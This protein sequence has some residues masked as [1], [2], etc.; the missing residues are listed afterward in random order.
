MKLIN[1]IRNVEL[2]TLKKFTCLYGIG[3]YCW[4]FSSF[5]IQVV[6]FTTFLY[7]NGG[8]NIL[9]PNIAFVS[10]SLFNMVRLPLYASSFIATSAVQTKVG[11][12]RITEFLILEELD[13]SQVEHNAVDG[14][15]ITL[16]NASLNW[17]D[18][19]NEI[20]LRKI[21]LRV[22]ISMTAGYI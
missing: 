17:T 1:D 22:I 15:S 7:I 6:T 9:S 18:D 20:T 3:A 4:N 10:L 5:M 21:N 2:K 8:T 12:R 14:E 19:P 16:Q 13:T 11:L